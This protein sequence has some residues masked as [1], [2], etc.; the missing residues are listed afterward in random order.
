MDEEQTVGLGPLGQAS[1][2]VGNMLSKAPLRESKGCGN[3]MQI[4]GPGDLAFPFSGPNWL[5]TT[6]V[7]RHIKLRGKN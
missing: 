3:L 7:G 6:V 1:S 4:P 5:E 2:G